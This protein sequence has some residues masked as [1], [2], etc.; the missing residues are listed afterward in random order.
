MISKETFVKAIRLIQEQGEIN[1]KVESVLDLVGD[2][3]Y[4]F[5]GAPKYHEALMLVLKE[6]MNDKYD[7]IDWW[8]FE[9]TPDY[10]VWSEDGKKEWC[11]KEP[12]A[13]YDFILNECQT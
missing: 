7:Y 1:D 2:G 11:L 13:L 3:H 12:E 9:A 10:Q 6:S 4:V 8:F 5:F